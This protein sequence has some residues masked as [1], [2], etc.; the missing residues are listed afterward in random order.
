MSLRLST[1]RETSKLEILTSKASMDQF[2]NLL[3]LDVRCLPSTNRRNLQ[4]RSSQKMDSVV[5]E[6]ILQP[7]EEV[8]IQRFTEVKPNEFSRVFQHKGQEEKK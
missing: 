2:S 4:A 3:M 6:V 7:M 1:F 5:K 8:W